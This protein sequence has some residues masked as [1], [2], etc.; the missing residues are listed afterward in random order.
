[1]QIFCCCHIYVYMASVVPTYASLL[2]LIQKQQ[3]VINYKNDDGD[4]I[5][6]TNE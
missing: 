3:I 6:T 4:N 5:T 1:M 2:S